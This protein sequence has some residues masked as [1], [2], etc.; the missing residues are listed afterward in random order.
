M[1]GDFATERSFKNCS[2]RDQRTQEA[3]VWPAA[4]G[5]LADFV[6]LLTAEDLPPA[7]FAFRQYSTVVDAEK[8]LRLLQADIRAGPHGQRSGCLHD[9]LCRLHK[10]V[11][12]QIFD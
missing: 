11:L 3:S 4:I 10:I 9:D 7:P 5:A 12:T 8:F 2:S 6:L 1:D